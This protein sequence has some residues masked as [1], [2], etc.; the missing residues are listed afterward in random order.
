LDGKKCTFDISKTVS[1]SPSF[2]NENQNDNS[3][4]ETVLLCKIFL[5]EA[6]LIKMETL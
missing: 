2:T 3:S 4:K 5:D 1:E 6:Q